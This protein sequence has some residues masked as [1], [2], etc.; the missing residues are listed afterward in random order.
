MVGPGSGGAA[1]EAVFGNQIL[2]VSGMTSNPPSDFIDILLFVGE[3]ITEI[4]ASI[5]MT[6]RHHRRAAFQVHPAAA[7]SP[8]SPGVKVPGFFRR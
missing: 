4:L 2:G 8:K 1:S 6:D 3:E 5:F 7:E